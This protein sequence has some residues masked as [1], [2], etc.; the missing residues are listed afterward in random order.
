VLIGDSFRVTHSFLSIR[1]AAR[2]TRGILRENA[3]PQAIAFLVAKTN[4]P[5]VEKQMSPPAARPSGD[6][7][8]APGAPSRSP[9]RP[10]PSL[11]FPAASP[12]QSPAPNQEGWRKDRRRLSGATTSDGGLGV[13]GWRDDRRQASH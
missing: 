3:A 12:L 6:A 7:P 11:P 8:P 2:R 13:V 4:G 9:S 1:H 10:H 5:R